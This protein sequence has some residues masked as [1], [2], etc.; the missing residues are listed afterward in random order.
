MDPSGCILERIAVAPDV[1]LFQF[2]GLSPDGR[3]LAI[4]WER[5]EG[6]ARDRGAYLLDLRSGAREDLPA[7]NNAVSFSP[8]GTTLI[9]A[10]FSADRRTEIFTQNRRTGATETVASDPAADFLPSFSPDMRRVF[11]NSYRTG[12]SDIY[13]LDTKT[14]VLTRLTSS[15]D[16][17]AYA[18]ISPDGRQLAF[19]RNVGGSGNYEVV[20]LN[21]DTG[22]ERT[23]ASAPGE[24]AYPAWSPDGQTILFSS[25]RA[26]GGGQ[27]DLYVADAEG[28]SV[29]ALTRA[30]GGDTYA[31]WAPNGRD[32]YFVSR[33]EGLQGVY[34]LRLNRHLQCAREVNR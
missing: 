29:R 10:N 27:N 9:G 3:T 16:Y 8:D 20:L 32:V 7:F 12:A 11:F 33:R 5:R 21:L 1:A 28:D 2:N 31:A 18:S 17:E 19:H 24:D 25:D 14:G 4:G 23:F 13:V 15:E 34:R 22:V 26:R 6:N 30:G